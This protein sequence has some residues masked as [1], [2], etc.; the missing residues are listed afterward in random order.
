MSEIRASRKP[1]SSKISFAA[2]SS[3]ARV[4]TPLLERGADCSSVAGDDT[5]APGLVASASGLDVEQPGEVAAHELPDGL[6]RELL[7]Q[8]VDRGL[9]VG[10]ALGVRPVGAEQHPVLTEQV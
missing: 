5:E 1:C 6:L 7:T 2:V 3:R 10:K 8:L 9:R 4:R